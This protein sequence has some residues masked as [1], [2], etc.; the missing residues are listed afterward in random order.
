MRIS[1]KA[2]Y[3]CLAVFEL[4]KTGSSGQ[5]RRV[6]EIAEAQGIPR[7]IWSKFSYS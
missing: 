7:D 3:A 2:E 4:A 6:R 5:Q 1:A